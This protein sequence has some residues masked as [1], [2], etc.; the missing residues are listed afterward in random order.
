MIAAIRA[1][2]GKR[3][4]HA[5]RVNFAPRVIFHSIAQRFLQHTADD[6]VAEDLFEPAAVLFQLVSSYQR[7]HNKDNCHR[8]QSRDKAKD[9]R[10][11]GT[12][13]Q[14]LSNR[15]LAAQGLELGLQLLIRHHLLFFHDR[16]LL[17][18]N[19]IFTSSRLLASAAK[20]SFGWREPASSLAGNIAIAVL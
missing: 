2:I 14:N 1:V 5:A 12:V 10:R 11:A 19:V 7:K 3:K 17:Y 6:I 8:D 18:Q 15:C 16:R 20:N 13:S 9:R 4:H